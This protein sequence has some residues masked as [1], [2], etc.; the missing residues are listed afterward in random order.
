MTEVAEG[1]W[2]S[3]AAA[4]VI[5][6][7][8]DRNERCIASSTF[9]CCLNC[10]ALALLTSE[11]FIAASITSLTEDRNARLS[12]SLAS[13]NDFSAHRLQTHTGT[14]RHT[15]FS[16]SSETHSRKGQRAC[17]DQ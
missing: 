13:A 7:T 2:M 10:S 8:T 9:V 16:Q 6:S 5:L 15:H 11:L 17:Y 1:L 3:V 12:A 14:H 4:L